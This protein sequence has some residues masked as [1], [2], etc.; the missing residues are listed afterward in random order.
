MAR[1]RTR[2]VAGAPATTRRTAPAATEPLAAQP[3][4]SRT[5]AVLENGMPVDRPRRRRVVRE[6]VA[7]RTV[8]VEEPVD[9]VVDDPIAYVPTRR[10]AWSPAQIASLALGAMF[11]LLGAVALV[12][13]SSLGA[14]LTGAE[15][16]IAGFHHTGLLGLLELALGM[17]LIALAA[18]PGGA[19]PVMATIGALLAVVGLYV[20]IAP[21]SLHP[22]LGVH[23]GHGIL[24]LLAGAVLMVA[25]LAAPLVLPGRRRV[26]RSEQ[27]VEEPVL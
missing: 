18:V 6:E 20:A 9:I 12:R 26:L 27:V 21:S 15:A 25:A 23:G 16:S 19:R 2:P 7:P 24:Y 10:E 17:T 11:L 4:A 1:A 5:G 13:T 3:V 14:G 22:S 8:L